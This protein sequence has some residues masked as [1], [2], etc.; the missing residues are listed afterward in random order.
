MKKIIAISLTI[1]T[2]FLI[3]AVP[4]SASSLSVLNPLQNDKLKEIYNQFLDKIFAEEGREF[5]IAIFKIINQIELIIS[6]VLNFFGIEPWWYIV[7]I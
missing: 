4:V 7:H 1:I 2:I 6:T 3:M 5:R